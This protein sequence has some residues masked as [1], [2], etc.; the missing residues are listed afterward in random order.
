[1]SLIMAKRH[2]PL[3]SCVICG[4]KTTKRELMRIVAT[5]QDTVVT[6]PTGRMPGRGA[7]VCNDGSCIGQGLTR[8]RLEHALRTTLEDNTFQEI[9]SA[10]QGL[11]AQ[12]LTM[13]EKTDG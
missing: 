4:N 11:S 1:M 7:Y 12:G 6:D 13:D 10:V 5:S 9:H 2:V 8:G 3:R